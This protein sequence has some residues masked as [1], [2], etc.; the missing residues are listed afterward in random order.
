MKITEYPQVSKMKLMDVTLIDGEDGTRKVI[1]A[2]LPFAIMNLCGSEMH[3]M[4][5]RGKNLGTEFTAIQKTAIQTGTFEDLWL[6]DYW[7][8]DGTTWRIV[9]IDYWYSCGDSKFVS[10]HAVIMPDTPLYSA[11]MNETDITNGGYTGSGMYTSGLTDAKDIAS[12]AFGNN[13]LTHREYLTNAV[14]DGHPSAGDWFDSTLDLPNEIM[15]YGC[16]IYASANNGTTIPNKYTIGKTQL[17]LFM[18]SPK[19]ISNGETFWLRDVVSSVDFASVDNHGSTSYYGAS[20][21]FGVRPV[22]AIG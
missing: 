11:S 21:S 7:I 10:H 6:G 14:A 17:A 16:H 18:V 22:F 13:I 9:D 15:M 4:I 3:R 5:Y 12:A 2:D 8:I 20:N 19:M 1:G